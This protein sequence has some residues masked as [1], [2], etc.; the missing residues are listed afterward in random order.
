MIITFIIA[1]ILLIIGTIAL[2][3]IS[4]KSSSKLSTIA[5]LFIIFL[6]TGG[7]LLHESN[8]HK[9][10]QAI[11]VYRNNTELVITESVKNGIVTDCDTTVIFKK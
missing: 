7:I 4:E 10:P 6:A 3:T 1:I 9:Y 2:F 8:I 5:I 11:D